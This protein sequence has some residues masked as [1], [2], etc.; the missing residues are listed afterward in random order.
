MGE[1][2]GCCLG[3]V[4]RWARFGD[5]VTADNGRYQLRRRMQTW[6]ELVGQSAPPVSV[7][8]FAGLNRQATIPPQKNQSAGPSREGGER[9]KGRE[10]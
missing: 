5:E 8:V 3:K 1:E 7:S 9:K 4:V 2:W 10:D 6:Q